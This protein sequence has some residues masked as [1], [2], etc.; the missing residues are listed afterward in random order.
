MQR[1][2][3]QEA[4]SAYHAN[5]SG[6]PAEGHL[7]D[8][9]LLTK[10][11]KDK[12][13][14]FRLGYVDDPLPGHDMYKGMLAIPYIRRDDE[15]EWSVVSMRF[16]CLEDH[17]HQGHGKYNTVSGDR[18][19][20]FNTTALLRPGPRML[21]TEGEIDALTAQVYGFDAVAVPGASSW[22]THF[23][24]PLL[25]YET[26]FILA[27]GDKPG[28]DFARKVANALPNGRI[29]PCPPGEDVNSW[30]TTSEGFNQFKERIQ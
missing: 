22:Q 28:M 30:I 17:E 20:L 21:V 23:R 11:V 13:D 29:I 5:L 27:D 8:R 4:T 25:G 10:F 1:Q 26:V 19:R 9:G 24:E 15:G 2:L 7:A 12:T 16:R 18:P 14:R 6:S 3:L